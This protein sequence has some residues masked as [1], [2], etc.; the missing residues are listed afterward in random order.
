MKRRL[1]TTT[2]FV[3]V[4]GLVLGALALAG[5]ATAHD[6]APTAGC[7]ADY[8][9]NVAGDECTKTTTTSTP[10]ECPSGFRLSGSSCTRTVGAGRPR[11]PV[12]QSLDTQF[13]TAVCRGTRTVAAECPSGYRLSGSSCVRT[14]DFGPAVNKC[15]SGYRTGAFGICYRTYRAKCPSGYTLTSNGTCIIRELGLTTPSTCNAG[16]SRSRATCTATTAPVPTCNLGTPS[17]GR[18]VGTAIDFPTCSSGTRSGGTCTIATESTPTCSSGSLSGSSCVRTETRAP[19]CSGGTRSGG[20]CITSVTLRRT[21]SQSCP[22]GHELRDGKCVHN[23]SGPAP[24]PDPEPTATAGRFLI[25]S[26]SSVAFVGRGCHR[27]DITQSSGQSRAYFYFDWA[28]IDVYP[29]A[30]CSGTARAGSRYQG[31]VDSAAT[32]NSARLRGGQASG[33]ATI[34]GRRDQSEFGSA[35]AAFSAATIA[36]LPSADDGPAGETYRR[37]FSVLGTNRAAAVAGSGC[38]LAEDTALRVG[39]TRHYTLS[40]KRSGQGQLACTITAGTASHTITITF[41]PITIDGL[42]AT[43]SEKVGS[44]YQDPFS[45]LGTNRAAAVA[46]SGCSLAEDTALRAGTTRHYTLSA[47]AAEAGKVACTITAGTASQTATIDFA[48]PPPPTTPTTMPEPA[49][50]ALAAPGGLECAWHTQGNERVECTWDAATGATAGYTVKY[51]LTLNLRGTTSTFAS[52]K[53]TTRTEFSGGMNKYVAKARY[54]VAA[55]GPNGTGPFTE[56]ATAI[57]PALAAPTGVSAVCGSDGV[58]SVSWGHQGPLVPLGLQFDVEVDGVAVG[59]VSYRSLPGS[60]ESYAYRWEGA[61]SNRA[62]RVRVRVAP[63]PAGAALGEDRESAWSVPVTANKCAVFKPDG[64]AAASCNAHGVV[65]LQWDPVGGSDRYDLKNTAPGEESIDY[66]GPATE[67]YAQRWEGETYKIRIRARARTGQEWSGWTAPK[68]VKCPDFNSADPD[69]Q[70]DSPNG[71]RISTYR[72]GVGSSRWIDPPLYRYMLDPLKSETL[73][74]DNCTET[75]RNADGGGWIRTC[76]VYWTE[77]LAIQL[78]QEDFNEIYGHSQGITHQATEQAAHLHIIDGEA[79]IGPHRHCATT[80]G[81]CPGLDDPQAPDLAWHPAL[82]RPGDPWWQTGLFGIGGTAASGGATY[83]AT[84]LIP[85]L[86]K[87]AGWVGF[88]LGSAAS[89]GFAFWQRDDDHYNLTITGALDCLNHPDVKGWN[90]KT[91]TFA[92]TSTLGTYT[93]KTITEVAYCEKQKE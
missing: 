77:P 91:K 52:Q 87:K 43:G 82:P 34:T 9:L 46:G 30:D 66:E 89:F 10:A 49:G 63:S 51:E 86:S 55:K 1:A 84:K 11:C 88:L 64:F 29:T 23:S 37:S 22:V 81:T 80:D 16:D 5:T 75:K 6:P 65:R 85:Q 56:W 79:S 21:P 71:Q 40:A 47:T 33:T 74:R 25:N 72:G 93:T 50:G 48:A 78:S 12:G 15:P 4:L 24:S 13:G 45:V 35:A 57:R 7:D 26:Q 53:T 42:D 18:C 28:G 69:D 92:K 90:K 58:L 36:G 38:S 44:T 27:L 32:I 17:A 31:F 3:T 68:E 60:V 61:H 83:G 76:R 73:G 19:T 54:K 39:T 41:N 14:I 20:Q 8:A 67:V 59:A 62:H 2:I 70:W